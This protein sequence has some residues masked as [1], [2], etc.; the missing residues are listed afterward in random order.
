MHVRA[1]YEHRG[2]NGPRRPTRATPY[3]YHHAVG[4][5]DGVVCI[6]DTCKVVKMHELL[7]GTSHTRIPPDIIRALLLEKGFA[8]ELS[9]HTNSIQ[10]TNEIIRTL[11]AQQ[12]GANVIL[13][14]CH[15]TCRVSEHHDDP[16]QPDD[17]V[18]PS[19]NLLL[20]KLLNPADGHVGG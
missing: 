14:V 4:K 1:H 8:Q 6:Q 7:H 9:G 11:E 18:E 10:V 15:G 3:T 20:G 17:H 16:R 2:R 5:E 19:V 13:A 12:P